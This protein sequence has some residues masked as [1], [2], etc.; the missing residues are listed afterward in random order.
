M[1]AIDDIKSR[2][3][4]VD[5]ISQTVKLRKTGKNF[6]GFCP[7]HDNR[8]TPAFVVFPETG[9]WRC[10]GQCNEGG[11]I[12]RFV[13]KKEGWDFSQTL[14]YLAD[15]TGVVLEPM[16]PQRKEA[17][18]RQER[19]RGLLDQVVVFYRNQLVQPAGK[20]ALDYLHKRGLTDETIEKFGLGYAPAEWDAMARHFMGKGYV[21]DDLLDTGLISERTDGSGYYDKFR[22]R[23]MFPIH[24]MDGKMAGFGGRILDPNDVPKFMN[25]PQT[26]LFDKGRLLYGMDF[27]RQSI[28]ASDTAVIVEGY[29]DVILLHQ[30]GFQ[31]TVSPM[32]TALT[33]EQIKY[34]KRFARR[35]VL[36]LD[37]DAAGEKATLRGLD[38][39]RQALDRETEISAGAG[40]IFSARGLVRTES[41]LGADLR[42]TTIPDGMDPDEV[43]LRDPE[44][45]E[46]ILAKAQPIVIHVMETLAA[47]QDIKD[48]K[49]KT[50][51]AAQIV[52]LIDDVV[53]PVEKDA[54]RQRLARLLQVD[55]STLNINMGGRIVPRTRR[56]Q[57]KTPFVSTPSV[58]SI[59]PSTNVLEEH[60]LAMLL[61]EPDLTYSLNR[62]LQRY[63]LT[64][65]TPSEME[66]TDHQSLAQAVIDALE[67]EELAPKDFLAQ[68]LS[69]ELKTRASELIILVDLEHVKKTHQVEDVFRAVVRKRQKQVQND[70]SQLR[71][72]QQE[73]EEKDETLDRDFQDRITQHARTLAYLNKAL[74]D[75]Q[76]LD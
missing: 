31:N 56:V 1:T 5:T 36:A 28:R 50:E 66:R 21:Y 42:V 44:E 41:R 65:F 47:R 10:F 18:D 6:I 24:T 3:D 74:F 27:A 55:E 19:L 15:K 58:A 2:L 70:I 43:V 38:V 8:N 48:P 62:V 34:L 59:N 23:I 69:N 35:I 73:L 9:T 22:N 32:G 37:A 39:A 17:E 30:A 25:S 54:Y 26:S 63:S 53:S 51:L 76:V 60:I 4:V 45:W 72:L 14:K 7:F 67:Q 12:F 52:P 61:S 46:Q 20:L 68:E 33:E 40:G 16:T 13:M 49:V 29:L 71:F 57:K 11:D 75:Q 64:V